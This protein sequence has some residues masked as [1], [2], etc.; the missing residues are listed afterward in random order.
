MFLGKMNRIEV[1]MEVSKVHPYFLESCCV[2]NGVSD[3]CLGLCIDEQSTETDR[4]VSICHKFANA[5]EK[6]TIGS[7]GNS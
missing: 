7:G 4:F 6:C 2:A 5:V 1:V 3:E